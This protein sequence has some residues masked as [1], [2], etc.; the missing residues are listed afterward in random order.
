MTDANRSM[1]ALVYL[2]TK[3]SRKWKTAYRMHPAGRENMMKEAPKL[4]LQEGWH[5][6][7]ITTEELF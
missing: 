7:D 5:A 1:I 4:A 3:A 2:P 6:W